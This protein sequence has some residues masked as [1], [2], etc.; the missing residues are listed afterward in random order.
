MIITNSW[1]AYSDSGHSWNN[2]S[3]FNFYNGKLNSIHFFNQPM[4]KNKEVIDINALNRRYEYDKNGNILFEKKYHNNN[5]SLED[6]YSYTENG[7]LIEKRE[8]FY[9]YDNKNENLKYRKKAKHIYYK[10]VFE[11]DKSGNIITKTNYHKSKPHKKYFY[12]YDN[13]GNLIEDGWLPG[14]MIGKKTYNPLFKYKY[15]IKG[16]KI[17][18]ISVGNFMPKNTN[19]F[20]EYNYMGKLSSLKG[21]YIKSDTTLGY[22]YIYRY[23]SIGQKILEQQLIGSPRTID[24][25]EYVI[26]RFE[27]D[28]YS[29]LIS[30]KYLND[31][32]ETIHLVRFEYKYDE[33]GNW[34]FKKK[35]I[36]C[37]GE[38]EQLVEYCER[39]IN[40]YK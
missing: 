20:Y 22:H 4:L 39:T 12:K 27:Y 26:K 24:W 29:N 6:Q 17:A 30:E 2:T 25:Q 37:F 7:L 16:Q 9:G 19:T 21:F 3:T 11:Y 33:K 14:R 8:C 34:V 10:S 36:K 40:Y 32:N 15:N 31:N 28:R 18:K 38:V 13:S 1:Y 35:F 5:L 23:D